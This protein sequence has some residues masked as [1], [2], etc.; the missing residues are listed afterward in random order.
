MADNRAWLIHRPSGKFV[1]LG[2]RL[3][4]EWYGA[5]AHVGAQLEQFLVGVSACGGNVDDFVLGLEDVQRAPACVEI[6]Y[7]A[8][9]T[10]FLPVEAMADAPADLLAT[11]RE[12]VGPDGPSDLP[13]HV[14]ELLSAYYTFKK[15]AS[16]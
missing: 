4:D 7:S 1:F 5:P 8:P 12:A 16:Q 13:E 2:K 9:G 14:F 3:G 11:L 15:R 6:D 10:P